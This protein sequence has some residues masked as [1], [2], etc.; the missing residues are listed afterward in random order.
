MISV[1]QAF[2]RLAYAKG[3]KLTHLEFLEMLSSDEV[4]R[5]NQGA[6]TRRLQAARVDYDQVLERFDWDSPVQRITDQSLPPDQGESSIRKRY[7]L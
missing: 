5:K 4:E 2:T 6:L 1:G 3:N 7:V